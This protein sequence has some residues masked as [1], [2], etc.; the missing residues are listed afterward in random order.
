MRKIAAK[1]SK[2]LNKSKANKVIDLNDYRQQ[3][4]AT[5]ELFN[6]IITP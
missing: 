3:K 2:R 4:K 6:E 5:E 1:V